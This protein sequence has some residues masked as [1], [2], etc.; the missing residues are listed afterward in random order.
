[1]ISADVQ[2]SDSL[3][4]QALQDTEADP[5]QERSLCPGDFLPKPTLQRPRFPCLSVPRFA[6]QLPTPHV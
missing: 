6:E 3:F 4:V 5:L 2:S 1:M